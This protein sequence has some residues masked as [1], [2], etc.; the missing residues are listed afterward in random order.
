MKKDLEGDESVAF[1]LGHNRQTDRWVAGAFVDGEEYRSAEFATREEAEVELGREMYRVAR[2]SG[3]PHAD[4]PHDIAMQGTR[5][6]RAAEIAA[7]EC[8]DLHEAQRM[9]VAADDA[10]RC[11]VAALVGWLL[12]SSEAPS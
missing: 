4:I 6:A 9:R 1:W 2:R 10:W 5:L 7:L 3:I 12:S 8:A 11:V